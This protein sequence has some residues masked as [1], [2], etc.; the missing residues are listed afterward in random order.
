MKEV[1]YFLLKKLATEAPVTGGLYY[2]G[3]KAR[4][5]FRRQGCVRRGARAP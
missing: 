2:D 5:V 4:L 1:G 3:P